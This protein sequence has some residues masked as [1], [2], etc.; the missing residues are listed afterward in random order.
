VPLKEFALGPVDR[1]AGQRNDLPV[2]RVELL[3]VAEVV[4]EPRADPKLVRRVDGEVAAVE[5][6]VH[7]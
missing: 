6:R 7:I 4:A 2:P 3:A 1:P 5:H